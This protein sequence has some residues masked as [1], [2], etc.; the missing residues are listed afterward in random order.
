[1]FE[2]FNDKRSEMVDT[3]TGGRRIKCIPFVVA[4][5]GMMYTESVEEL[6]NLL[7]PSMSRNGAR[8]LAQNVGLDIVH[9][10]VKRMALLYKTW[11]RLAARATGKRKAEEHRGSDQ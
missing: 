11:N 3:L 10:V 7:C 6:K 9:S 4:M 5:N 2:A 1:M 8:Q